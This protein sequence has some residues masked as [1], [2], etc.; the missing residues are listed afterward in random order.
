MSET[1]IHIFEK[2]KKLKNPILIEGLPGIGNVG[3][4]AAGYLVN[5]MKAKKIAE[6]YSPHFLPLIVVNEKSMAYLLKSEF[7]LIKGK[8]N[9]FIVLIGDF[10]STTS[11]GYYEI[12]GKILDFA[13]QLGVKQIVT[14]GGMA[15]GKI[16]KEPKIYGV[17][18]DEK[19]IKKLK[20][21]GINFKPHVPETIVGI[22]GILV[23][24]AKIKG[25][26]AFSLMAETPGFPFMLADPIAADSMLRILIDMFGFD[27][28]LTDL[29][30]GVKELE[31]KIKKAEEIHKQMLQKIS[32]ERKDLEYIG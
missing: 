25:I 7:F 1:Y 13:I 19:L 27:V 26:P 22:S 4:A 2:P 32:E 6:M 11:D 21:Y 18:N 16:E 9:D 24:L 10:Q 23:G 30:K 3:R 31:E 12:S 15:T 20:K 17:V 14:L 29:E 8:T 5:K 28:D